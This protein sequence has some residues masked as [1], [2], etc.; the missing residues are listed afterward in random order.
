MYEFT[1]WPKVR[2]IHNIRKD[3]SSKRRFH[4]VEDLPTYVAPTY[5][6]RGKIKLDGTNA[7]VRVGEDSFVTQSR[8]RVITPE[9]DNMGFANWVH[10]SGWINAAWTHRRYPITVFGEWCGKGIQKRCAISKIDRKVFCVF[11]VQVD[12]DQLVVDP[13]EIAK[14]I[15]AHEDVFILPWMEEITIDLDSAESMSSAVETLNN[16]VDSCEECD[17]WVKDTFN[18]EDLGEGIVFYPV[19]QLINGSEE[20]VK[21]DAN[22]MESWAFKAKGEKHQ[23]V[24]QKKSVILDPELVSG[25]DAF[26]T[27]FVTENRLEQGLQEAC[28][29]EADMRHTGTF[30][31]WF[32]NDVRLESKDELEASGLEW[33]DVTKA[34]EKAARTWWLELCR[35]S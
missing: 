35:K 9:D 8:S 28:N 20:S 27:K 22:L 29:G 24:K 23:V 6:Y 31:K 14:M 25:V 19:E 34:V 21:L 4:E 26:V 5:R 15:P 11:A 13:D 33:K 12:Y 7:A 16:M 2:Q 32:G 18:I 17:P 1:K 10:S 30:M 3:I